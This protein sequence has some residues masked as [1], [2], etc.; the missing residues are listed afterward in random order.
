M[1]FSL[2]HLIHVYGYL[3]VLIGTFLEGETILLLAGMAAAQGYLLLPGVIM[4][5]F[6]GSFAGD[7]LFF[8]IGRRY[9]PGFVQRRPGLRVAAARLQ[10]WVLRHRILPVVG[11]RFLYGLRSAAPFVFGASGIGRRRFFVLN[12]IGAIVWAIALGYAGFAAGRAFA[13]FV[14]HFQHDELMFLLAGVVG[15][16]IWL[17]WRYRS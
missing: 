13:A 17:I 6:V 14:G 1:T 7:Q 4:A 9:G 2:T 16:G 5:A 12:G 3:A 15:A 10:G 8:Y 11:F